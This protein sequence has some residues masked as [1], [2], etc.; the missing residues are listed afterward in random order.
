MITNV[1]RLGEFEIRVWPSRTHKNYYTASICV[2]GEVVEQLRDR[3]SDALVLSDALS[4]CIKL[5][6]SANSALETPATLYSCYH[7]HACEDKRDSTRYYAVIYKNDV[8]V[9]SVASRTKSSLAI[10]DAIVFLRQFERMQQILNK[11]NLPDSSNET[12]FDS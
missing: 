4:T 12:T 9:A 1:V 10:A 5:H 7:I 11:H 2:L 3:T 6:R 8:F